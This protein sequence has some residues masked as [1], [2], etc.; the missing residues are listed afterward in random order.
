MNSDSLTMRSIH[1]RL[2]SMSKYT[3]NDARS[4]ARWFGSACSRAC[5]M[6]RRRSVLIAR[7]TAAKTSALDPKY[8]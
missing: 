5:F 4:L 8:E 7:T 2:D 6:A 3:R 1:G